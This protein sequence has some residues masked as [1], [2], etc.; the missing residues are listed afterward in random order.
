M[1][2][3]LF[4]DSWCFLLSGSAENSPQLH[5]NAPSGNAVLDLADR[6]RAGLWPWKV[7]PHC[8][9]ISLCPLLV[10]SHSLC[11]PL[12]P[13]DASPVLSHTSEIGPLL[14]WHPLSTADYQ[15]AV[16][17]F[18][19]SLAPFSIPCTWMPHSS[20]IF[21]HHNLLHNF[22]THSRLIKFW[23]DERGIRLWVQL[24]AHPSKSDAVV[25]CSQ[26]A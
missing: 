12:H 26:L 5:K 23:T 13:P 6:P 8:P 17:L 19:E 18:W 11:I 1:C 24:A 22:G 10:H 15:S 7:R 14:A 20:T 3:R 21:A 9:C 16:T 25:L 2:E 4:Q